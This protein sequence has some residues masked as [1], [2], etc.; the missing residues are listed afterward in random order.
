MDRP[1]VTD[2]FERFAAVA[3]TVKAQSQPQTTVAD[4]LLGLTEE[5]LASLRAWSEAGLQ[6]IIDI[7]SSAP[8]QEWHAERHRDLHVERLKGLQSAVRFWDESRVVPCTKMLTRSAGWLAPGLLFAKMVRHGTAWTQSVINGV[9]SRR[10]SDVPL[11]PMLSAVR[12]FDLPL[13]DDDRFLVLW[14]E[15]FVERI[16]W[17]YDP[18]GGRIPRHQQWH[19]WEVGS[20]GHVGIQDV[21]REDN[22]WGAPHLELL[23]CRVIGV[24]AA[25]QV[26]HMSEVDDATAFSVAVLDAVACGRIARQP[27]LDAVLDALDSTSYAP[28]AQRVL[29]NLLRRLDLTSD[30]VA[31]NLPR[32]V[33]LLGVTSSMAATQ[34]WERLS[35]LDLDPDDLLE[36]G[37]VLLS[38]KE[39]KL[40]TALVAYLVKLPKTSP[41]IDAAVELCTQA[42]EVDDRAVAGRARTFVEKHAPGTLGKSPDAPVDDDPWTQV[43][44]PPPIVAWRTPWDQT[45][46]T[47][48]SFWSPS[49]SRT[50]DTC[51]GLPGLDAEWRYR[52]AGGTALCVPTYSDWTLSFDDLLTRVKAA[53]DEGYW[54]HDLAQALLR[55]EPTDPARASELD[56][57]TLPHHRWA[58]VP[59]A[60]RV[61]HTIEDVKALRAKTGAGISDIGRALEEVGGNRDKAE[62]LL[63]TRDLEGG[64]WSLT[65]APDGVELIRTWVA[66][67]GIT[68]PEATC[69]DLGNAVLADLTLPV[70]VPGVPVMSSQVA[71]PQVVT[72]WATA[73]WEGGLATLPFAVE[74]LCSHGQATHR[75]RNRG[76]WVGVTNVNLSNARG[77]FGAATYGYLA[78]V[79][80]GT[81]D[82]RGLRPLWPSSALAAGG[83]QEVAALVL[84]G[85]FDAA[86]FVE[87]LRTLS[88]AESWFS[89]GRIATRCDEVA[90]AGALH[91]IWPVITAM[92]AAAV[93]SPKIPVGTLDLLKVATQYVS[94]AA[95]HLPPDD[96]VPEQVRAFAASKSKTKAA[97]EARAW[98]DRATAAGVTFTQPVS[99]PVSAVPF[100]MVW[101]HGSGTLPALVDGARLIIRWDHT[102]AKPELRFDITLPNSHETFRTFA[103]WFRT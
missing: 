27:V 97:L 15:A 44:A 12:H 92:A 66:A 28:A 77:P 81:D 9:L 83:S 103:G 70:V 61:E 72:W 87:A 60:V 56:G 8:C 89:L 22:L 53:K 10:T 7:E 20:D 47:P 13:P 42:T 96:V 21:G 85:R 54:P 59:P 99:V 3:Q 69:D 33:S 62:W 38:R 74:Y 63:R 80:A 67:G 98:L 17:S 39:K 41:L 58:L 23:V 57:L 78:M 26:V 100:D 102:W 84:Q 82:H 46:A 35:G 18:A 51:T 11:G 32:M 79:F 94:T 50:E 75:Q 86:P 40:W 19:W 68:I 52:P 95:A 88:T 90:Q 101:P 65:D 6:E 14:A 71:Q 31:A 34:L 1:V 24:P 45:G 55:L 16:R 76:N 29:A 64:D 49:A 43:W 25:V 5:E 73:L 48:S 36:I 93:T 37:T 2:A 4:L 30:D 91:G